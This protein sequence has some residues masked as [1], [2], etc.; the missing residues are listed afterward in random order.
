ML[1]SVEAGSSPVVGVM[2]IE[3]ASRGTMGIAREVASSVSMRA[4]EGAAMSLES[5]TAAG[6]LVGW[7]VGGAVKPLWEEATPACK[8]Q[9]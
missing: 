9:R 4:V 3:A 1:E 5:F 8:A 6:T 7:L 2:G